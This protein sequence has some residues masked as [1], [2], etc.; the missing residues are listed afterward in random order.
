MPEL[1]ITGG[2][3]ITEGDGNTAGFTVT[4]VIPVTS[5]TVYY[6]PESANF[7]Q[8]GSGVATFT[9]LNFSVVMV[10]MLLRYQLRSMMMSSVR[11]T[12]RFE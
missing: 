8:A 3:T 9:T 2:M 5:L 12:V 1:K 6:T 11:A 10:P 7:L 4:S